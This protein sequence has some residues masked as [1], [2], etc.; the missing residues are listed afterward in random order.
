MDKKTI[1]KDH[2]C[3]CGRDRTNCTHSIVERAGDMA[4]RRVEAET[5]DEELNLA[6]LG[7]YQKPQNLVP[8][9]KMKY[10]HIDFKTPEE[11]IKFE[12]RIKETKQIY[13]EKLHWYWEEMR[14][15]QRDHD[16]SISKNMPGIRLT[17]MYN[18]GIA[19]AMLQRVC[20]IFCQYAHRS[21]TT[22]TMIKWNPE[23]SNTV[24]RNIMTCQTSKCCSLNP[25]K[26]AEK[27]AD[28]LP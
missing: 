28:R 17:S 2:S 1:I 16:V 4:A 23:I 3:S 9:K 14:T 12:S 13:N 18:L 7:I 27:P 20:R 15:Q 5:P 26:G 8:V 19:K 11:R 22:M 21:T 25:P 10:I 6:T 24:R